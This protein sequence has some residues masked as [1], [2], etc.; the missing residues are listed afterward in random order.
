GD[1][2][3]AEEV[4]VLKLV[5]GEFQ[6][7]LGPCP[8]GAAGLTKSAVRP[9]LEFALALICL[10]GYGLDSLAPFQQLFQCQFLSADMVQPGLNDCHSHR[11]EFIE[12][13]E[14]VISTQGI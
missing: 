3:N 4:G 11:L 12:G 14:F 10:F 13:A 6:M 7:M 1:L 8:A 5:F 2:L 9:G